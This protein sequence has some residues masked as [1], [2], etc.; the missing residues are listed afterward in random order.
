[1]ASSQAPWQRLLTLVRTLSWLEPL[2]SRQPTAQPLRSARS[3]PQWTRHWLWRSEC[4]VGARVLS[5]PVGSPLS[6][7]RVCQRAELYAEPGE[8]EVSSLQ[9]RSNWPRAGVRVC[10]A[11]SPLNGR[12]DGYRYTTHLPTARVLPKRHVTFPLSSSHSPLAAPRGQT[13]TKVWWQNFIFAHLKRATRASPGSTFRS[14]C[15]HHTPTCQPKRLIRLPCLLYLPRRS[16]VIVSRSTCE[17][18][19]VAMPMEV[20]A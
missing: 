20:A 18:S 9:S 4:S 17:S 14:H 15:P 2:Y 8:P 13:L 7:H 10:V 16:L 12:A 19:S 3:A 1:M 6:H 11:V 5:E